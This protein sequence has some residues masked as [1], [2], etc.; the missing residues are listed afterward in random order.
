MAHYE[1]VIRFC[2]HTNQLVLASVKITSEDTMICIHD[3]NNLDNDKIEVINW[4]KEH[5]LKTL[6]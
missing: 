6:E 2:P 5:G 3:D 1:N 4:L